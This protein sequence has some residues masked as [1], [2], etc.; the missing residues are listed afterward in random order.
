LYCCEPGDADQ[1][2]EWVK[3]EDARALVAELEAKIVYLKDSA[4]Q[5]YSSYQ[6]HLQEGDRL[7]KWLAEN[8][9][10]IN[11]QA[12]DVR[13]L[14]TENARLKAQLAEI[15]ALAELDS[16]TFG[17]MVCAIASRETTG[18]CTC[19]TLAATEAQLAELREAVA[20]Y[21]EV[22]AAHKTSMFQDF[23]ESAY[24]ELLASYLQAEAD[25]KRLAGWS[26]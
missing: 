7:R 17:P 24:Y 21:V 2:G 26:P 11:K 25:L 10:L 3:A 22:E 6:F 5:S 18:G 4:Q 20:W 14:E 23:N 16:G 19:E 9:A 8:R 12:E 13:A 15:R 1:S